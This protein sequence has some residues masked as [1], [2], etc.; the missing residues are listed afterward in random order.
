M[1]FVGIKMIEP[2]LSAVLRWP[3]DGPTGNIEH[4]LGDLIPFSRFLL[5]DDLNQKLILL[6]CPGNPLFAD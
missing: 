6:F 5:L 2:S 4:I 3:E 1:F